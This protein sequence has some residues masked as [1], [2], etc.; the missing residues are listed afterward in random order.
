MCVYIYIYCI[1]LCTKSVR[2]LQGWMLESL[3]NSMSSENRCHSFAVPGYTVHTNLNSTIL[4]LLQYN[5]VLTFWL[6]LKNYIY[7]YI[8]NTGWA[9][10]WC[11]QTLAFCLSWRRPSMT[12]ILSTNVLSSPSTECALSCRH[13]W[14]GCP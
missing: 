10:N 7:I 12:P 6:N 11:M 14:L 3:C 1:H 13:R 4:K 9:T 8:S 5:L 2:H